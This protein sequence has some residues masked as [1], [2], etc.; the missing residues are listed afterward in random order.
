VNRSVHPPL[1]RPGRGDRRADHRPGRPACRGAGAG[2]PGIGKTTLT[3][4]V[5]ASDALA[6]R[7]AARRWFVP[8]E[9]ASDA[10][11]LRTA[12]VLALGGNPA[13][14]AAFDLA[15]AR[16]REAPACCWTI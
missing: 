10:V 5:A 14:P 9:T 13:D 4:E 11:T 8:L 6:V 12:I 15:L 16:L 2:G 1:P 7:F 3:R